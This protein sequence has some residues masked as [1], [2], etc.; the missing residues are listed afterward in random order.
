MKNLFNLFGQEFKCKE[1]GEI[2]KVDI[3]GIKYGNLDGIDK[4]ISEIYGRNKKIL[5]LCD[6]ITYEVSGKR[7]CENLKNNALP[8]ILKPEN[9]KR[10]YAK[11]EYIEE[12]EKN[13]KDID[14]ILACGA[15]TITDLGKFTGEKNKIP[16]ISFP[17]APSMNGYTSPVAAYIKDGVKIT[18]PVKVCEYVYIDEDIIKDAP[19]ELIKAGFAD[20]L[21]KS[22]ANSDWKISSIITGEKF[23]AF[24]LKIVSEAERK[25]INKGN[26]IK[27]RD[28]KVVKSIM[29]GLNLGGISMIIAGS[30]SPASGGEHLI[31]HFLDMYSHQ[32]KI[33]PFSFHGLQ[34][35]IGIYISSLIYNLLKDFKTEDIE[36]GLRERKIDYDEKFKKIS[37]LFP[38]SKNLL[39]E[40][41][42]KKLKLTEIIKENLVARWENIKKEVIPMV[43]SPSEIEKFLKKAECPLH[44]SEICDDKKLIE[45][46]IL[47][48]RFIRE[49]ITILDIA[50]EIGVLDEFIYQY[51]K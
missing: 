29:D 32:N 12:I 40:I 43:Y 13:I 19:I 31:S 6:E 47:L 36:K 24:P 26:L 8:L 11:Y 23:C 18:N 48:S 7:I 1:C 2:H 9:E 45:N 25:Y 20:S 30:S 4:F 46:T 42:N 39:K 14:L 49:R 17:T 3:K 5:I 34:V 41:F 21:A 35:G 15:G 22:F 38:S 33:E 44:L 16:V 10:V 51:L 27:K 50:D 37:Y 28:K